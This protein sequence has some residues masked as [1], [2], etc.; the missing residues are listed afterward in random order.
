ML[1]A[2]VLGNNSK[3]IVLTPQSHVIKKDL[4]VETNSLY[5]QSGPVF[6]DSDDFL[7][8]SLTPEDVNARMLSWITGSEM[9]RG[10]NIANLNF[11]L[12]RLKDFIARFDN[13]N[14]YFIGIFSKREKLLIGFYTV[15]VSFPHMVALLT[16][17]IG[18]KGF[19]GKA[20]F[21]RTIDALMDYFYNYRNIY[22]IK[23]HVMERNL[24]ML[25]N[26]M[27]APHFELEAVLKDDFITPT[28]ERS[29][30]LVF[31]SFVH[32]RDKPAVFDRRYD[33]DLQKD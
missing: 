21:W 9:L 5:A 23:S 31:S 25:F 14:H 27:N 3:Y 11:D 24:R 30:I 13:K 33:K 22:K 7:L 6:I 10:L 18:E 20:V 1:F 32:N 26:Y 8:R 4:P 12:S 15:D 28:G 2:D 17:G 29:D 16:G 19:E